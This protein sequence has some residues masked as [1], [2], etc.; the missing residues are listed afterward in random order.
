MKY[1]GMQVFCQG[2]EECLSTSSLTYSKKKKKRIREILHLERAFFLNL[3]SAFTVNTQEGKG[4]SKVAEL[5]GMGCHVSN[6]FVNM[7]AT[8]R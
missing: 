2:G 7:E 5:L 6:I 1:Q 4:S 3:N 8:G